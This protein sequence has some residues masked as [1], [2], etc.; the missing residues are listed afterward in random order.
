MNEIQQRAFDM[1]RNAFKR[2]WAGLPDVDV[3]LEAL[4]MTDDNRHYWMR[5]YL[6]AKL[7]DLK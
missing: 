4:G 2:G 6:D 3:G 5:G 7:H 1:G